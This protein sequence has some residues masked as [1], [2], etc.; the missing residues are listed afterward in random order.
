MGQKMHPLGFRLGTTQNHDS[1]WFAQPRIYSE[2]LKEDKI[3]RDCIQNYIQKTSGVEGVGR[4]KIKKTIDKIQVI[5]YMVLPTLLTEEGK[6]PRIEELQTNVQK[7]VNCVTRKMNI[8]ITRIQNAYSDPNILAEFIAGQFKNRI[9]FRKAI[10][11]AIELADQ[12]GTKGVQVQIAGRIDG[13]EIARV[14]WIREGRVPLQTIRAKI[15][16][17]S[18]PVR[19]IYG[20]LGIKVWV[21]LN[22]D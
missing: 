2:N 10:K 16:Y 12:A 18:Y 3:I 20:V 5:I 21:F 8:T 15:D 7:K 17:C 19:T 4:I 22:N 6:P 13:K 14:E 1:I 11:K 9:S